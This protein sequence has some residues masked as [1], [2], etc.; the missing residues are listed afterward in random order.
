MM[1][2]PTG[3]KGNGWEIA[4][5]KWLRDRGAFAERLRLAGK[6]DEGDIV[7]ITA[8]KTY[9]LEAKNRKSI[10]LPTFWDEAVKEA[11]NYAKA[12]GLEQTPPAFVVVKRRNASVEK[13]FVI[14]DL[15]SWMRERQ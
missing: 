5:L 11:K 14:Q 6:N 15:E 10:S 9:I 12:R 13:A 7:C 8:G 3:R 1:A 4:I 2:N